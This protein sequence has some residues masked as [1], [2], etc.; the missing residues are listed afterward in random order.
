MTD[1]GRREHAILGP[2]VGRHDDV[3]RRV[4]A[5]D[6]ADDR[7]VDARP[8]RDQQPAAAP[9]VRRERLAAAQLEPLRGQQHD[10]RLR[11]QA[12]RPHPDSDAA[13]APVT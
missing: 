1:V 3:Q 11:G 9:H 12:R 7:A 6:V 4:G 8:G 5:E 2:V 13:L 10:R